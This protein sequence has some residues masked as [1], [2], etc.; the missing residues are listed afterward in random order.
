SLE[1][2]SPNGTGSSRQPYANTA[3][4]YA[5]KAPPIQPWS[6]EPEYPQETTASETV[7][8]RP[9]PLESLATIYAQ[10]EP[11]EVRRLEETETPRTTDVDETVKPVVTSSSD[12]SQDL[13]QIELELEQQL[14][15]EMTSLAEAAGLSEVQA[16]LAEAQ[17]QLQIEADT[18]S[19]ESESLVSFSI[20]PP[21]I[22]SPDVSDEHELEVQDERLIGDFWL[23]PT[24]DEPEEPDEVALPQ[25]NWPSPVL[26]PLRPPKRRK[27]LAAIELPSFT[28]FHPS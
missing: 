15:A 10:T 17:T 20:H 11:F 19:D 7:W 27:S 1:M 26:Y 13:T 23:E 24:P 14:L 4:L 21:E 3:P 12:L 18:Q 8:N 25:S 5:P 9:T 6:A 2:Q 22:P 16:E 28:R